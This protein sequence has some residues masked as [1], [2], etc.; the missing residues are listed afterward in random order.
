MWEW[1][2][3]DSW[4]RMYVQTNYHLGWPFR[5][6]GSEKSLTMSLGPFL[7]DSALYPRQFLYDLIINTCSEYFLRCFPHRFSRSRQRM[8]IYPYRFWSLLTENC[9]LGNSDARI[10]S[11]AYNSGYRRSHYLSSVLAQVLNFVNNQEDPISSQVWLFSSEI[12]QEYGRPLLE[13]ASSFL[14]R[15]LTEFAQ[16]FRWSIVFKWP[17]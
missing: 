13:M 10:R 2:K 3:L 7:S 5:E 4:L 16:G 15:L 14:L 6:Q 12:E 1:L 8:W 17:H 11:L 9:D